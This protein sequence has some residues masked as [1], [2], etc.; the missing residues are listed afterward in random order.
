MNGRAI[1]PRVGALLLGILLTVG[2]S[3]AAAAGEAPRDIPDG[4]QWTP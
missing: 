3:G 1:A 2:P 4:M